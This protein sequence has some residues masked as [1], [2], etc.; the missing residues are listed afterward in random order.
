VPAGEFQAYR[1]EYK[2]TS[3]ALGRPGRGT[4]SLTCWYVPHLHTMVA[5]DTESTWNGQLQSR[6]REELTSFTLTSTLAQR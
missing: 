6:E 4:F 5:L 1:I 2:G 3:T